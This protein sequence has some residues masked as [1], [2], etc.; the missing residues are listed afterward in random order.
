M[1][2]D[3]YELH[4]CRDKVFD[5]LCEV[6]NDA[7]HTNCWQKDIWRKANTCQ[8]VARYWQSTTDTGRRQKALS[9]MEEAYEFYLKKDKEAYWVDDFGWWGGFFGDLSG[10]GMA[11]PFDSATLLKEAQDC[12]DGMLKNLDTKQGGIRNNLGPTGEKNTVTNGWMLNLAA[13]LFGWAGNKFQDYKDV[14]LEQYRWLETGKYKEIYSPPSWV[15]YASNGMLLWL[16]GPSDTS[17]Y[18]SGD[19]GVFLRGL[20]RYIDN[21]I[22]DAETQK[23]LR[24]KGKNLII[25]AMKAFADPEH[26]MHA[27]PNPP[28]RS[29]DLATGKGVFM[30]LV[31]EFAVH[32]K[33]F[34]DEKFKKTFT[35]F[36]DLTAESAWCSRDTATNRTGPHWNPK[37][38]PA[39]ETE[40]LVDGEL[41]PLVWQT[42]GLDAL[43]AAVRIRSAG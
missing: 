33:F 31:T 40:Q 26:V 8:A 17:Q 16:P 23:T 15:L 11:A 18:W 9:I 6:W 14:A 34:D 37:F 21:I 29:N 12:Y 24:L 30:R 38:N 39:R 36:V 2:C 7:K 4:A 3:D 25:A 5:R 13:G 35:D 22:T 32:C 10:Q 1:K 27:S 28:D 41:W 42:D 19:E 20:Q 43:N